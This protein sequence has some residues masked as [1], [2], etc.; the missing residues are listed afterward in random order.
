MSIADQIT[1][2]KNNIAASYAECSAKGATLP[3]D[4]NS[5]NLPNTI[6][7]ISTGSEI[8]NQ[9]KTITANGTYT[10]DTGYTG[11][12]TVTVNVP[13][14]SGGG[15]EI[16][17]YN[18][19][20]T[21]Y[22]KGDWVNINTTAT[23]LQYSGHQYQG[24]S[25]TVGWLNAFYIDNPEKIFVM[26][27]RGLYS[28][29]G[30][31]QDTTNEPTQ[32]IAFDNPGG[33][34][35]SEDG[36]VCGEFNIIYNSDTETAVIVSE[37]QEDNTADYKVDFLSCGGRLGSG[38]YNGK[39]SLYLID[40]D[41]GNISKTYNYV[42][43]TAYGLYGV[44]SG[45]K[46]GNDYIVQTG[47]TSTTNTP[48]IELVN[49]NEDASTYSLTTILDDG[50]ARAFF[51]YEPESG[52]IFMQKGGS[53]TNESNLLA[54]TWDS[55][56]KQLNAYSVENFPEA[57][58]DCFSNSCYNFW[59]GK[60]KIFTSYIKSLDKLVCC[61]YLNGKWI[62]KSPIRQSYVGN[63]YTAF[64]VS[65]DF[66]RFSTSE[67]G[68]RYCHIY[69]GYGNNLA[70]GN[71]IVPHRYTNDTTSFM[72]KA[73]TDISADIGTECTVVIPA[74]ADV[75]DPILNIILKPYIPGDEIKPGSTTIDPS[76][77]KFGDRIDNKATVVGTFNS[78]DLGPVVFA[79]L[80]NKYYN[81]DCWAS[82]SGDVSG[83]TGLPN[84]GKDRID[85][86]GGV[87]E[88]F[89]TSKIR[90]SATYNTNYIINNYS[91]RCIE[92]FDYC[93]SIEPLKFNGK[94]YNCQLPNAYEVQ[95]IYNNRAKL[96]KLNSLPDSNYDEDI[97]FNLEKWN[98]WNGEEGDS[99]LVM[100]SNEGSSAVWQKYRE[101]MLDNDGWSA[102]PKNVSCFILPIIEIPLKEV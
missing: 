15:V 18:Y 34:T 41:T 90:E 67:Y 11:L 28:G 98:F 49:F 88:I 2:I 62:D 44:Y 52:I 89:E 54:Y 84:Y 6:A 48:K 36:Y 7:S 46:I 35:I 83:D 75:K 45:V 72:G 23:E 85:E 8:N 37:T 102:N 39:T 12:G 25:S 66:S 33:F 40:R 20:N 13:I 4:E 56:N 14:P 68:S 96:Y 76:K 78:V 87:T 94:T 1:R 70:A 17:A 58:R 47:L 43:A 53:V 5:E 71:Y 60:T 57:M 73:K 38:Y 42:E 100:T 26:E 82:D 31:L 27:K 101:D 30:Y 63:T 81:Y 80:D 91:D 19:S 16:T 79:I 86:F 3:T 92:A 51:G 32:I 10:A 61:Q 74:I 24:G 9:D 97:I 69:Q 21:K 55:T 59:N 77:L 95:Q 93:K 99:A 50:N 29:N 64:T 65:A 22:N